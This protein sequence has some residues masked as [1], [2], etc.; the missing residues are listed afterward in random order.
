MAGQ[1]TAQQ[2]EG[3]HQ[4]AESLKLYR[5]ADLHDA[6]D[7][8]SLIADL[9]VDPLPHDQALRTVLRQIRPLSLDERVLENRRF[10]KGSSMKSGKNK[11]RHLPT[12]TSKH[13]SNPRR[14]IPLCSRNFL[15]LKK[16][17]RRKSWN[18]RCYFVSFC[19]RLSLRSRVSF[20]SASKA[21]VGNG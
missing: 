2:L 8:S 14:W 20:E 1:W 4:A 7:G 13:Y 21:R 19:G 17:C 15:T 11:L 10:S 9:Y 12:S 3:F 16:R 5:R 6:E 18:A